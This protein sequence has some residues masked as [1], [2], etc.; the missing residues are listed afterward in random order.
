MTGSQVLIKGLSLAVAIATGGTAG[1]VAF[2]VDE[3][4]TLIV[5]QKDL[6][7]I[8][9]EKKPDFKKIRLDL[10]KECN[11]LCISFIKPDGSNKV[12]ITQCFDNCKD[13]IKI[14][15]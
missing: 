4:K 14:E 5:A 7:K 13:T 9:H 11:D 12:F 8:S 10:F 3:A 2:A 15:K 6:E 1:A